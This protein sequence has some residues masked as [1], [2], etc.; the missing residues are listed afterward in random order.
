VQIWHQRYRFSI[1]SNLGVTQMNVALKKMS[2]ADKLRA[3]EE[4]W[5]DLTT[6]NKQHA[7]PSWHFDELEK[8]ERAIEAGQMKFQDWDKAKQSIRRRAK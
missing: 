5:I 4:L 3:M 6:G 8:T 7:S 1:E 2:R